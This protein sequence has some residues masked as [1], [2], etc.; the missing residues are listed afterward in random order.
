MSAMT[1]IW[2]SLNPSKIKGIFSKRFSPVLKQSLSEGCL[3]SLAEVTNTGLT[4][5][6]PSLLMLAN[7]VQSQKLNQ[8]IRIK[9]STLQMVLSQ[10]RD[11]FLAT[12][13]TS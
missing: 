8:F 2:L 1:P 10:D 9:V 11:S 6:V 5:V 4:F 13:L 3:Y 7:A 12:Y